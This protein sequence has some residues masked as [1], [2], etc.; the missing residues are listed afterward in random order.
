MGRTVNKDG[1]PI[2]GELDNLPD[3][4]GANSTVEEEEEDVPRVEEILD[5]EEPVAV[6]KQ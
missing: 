4:A 1:S 2:Y 6:K 5:D 3:Q